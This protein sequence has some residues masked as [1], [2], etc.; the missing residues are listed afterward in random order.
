MD[1]TRTNELPPAAV[2]SGQF[3]IENSGQPKIIF[4]NF[5]K[6]NT[7]YLYENPI[8]SPVVKIV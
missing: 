4:P 6:A 7:S 2:E 3:E 1:S 8:Q 5:S